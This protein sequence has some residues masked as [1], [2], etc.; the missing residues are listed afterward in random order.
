MILQPPP[1]PNLHVTKS[2]SNT[3]RYI[4]PKIHPYSNQGGCDLICLAVVCYR[5]F[6]HVSCPVDYTLPDYG[7]WY[8][9]GP[10]GVFRSCPNAFD[11]NHRRYEVLSFLILHFPARVL[12]PVARNTVTVHYRRNNHPA[13]PRLFAAAV[14]SHPRSPGAKYG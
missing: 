5:A 7:T 6:S 8:V 13:I 4:A 14:T 10:K 12:L 2:T 1:P 11:I 3:A 9:R